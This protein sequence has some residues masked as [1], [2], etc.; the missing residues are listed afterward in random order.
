MQPAADRM[1]EALAAVDIKAPKVPVVAN[2]IAAPTSDPAA[3]RSLLVEQVT[4]SVR[5]RESAI[6]M[7]EKGVTRLVEVGAGKVL[8]GLAKRIDDRLE[9]VAVGNPQQIE[10]FVASLDA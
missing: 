2:V 6:F 1:A 9:G 8:T 10:E 4:G 7:A 5:W 3:I